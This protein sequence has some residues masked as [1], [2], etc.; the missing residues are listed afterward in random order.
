MLVLGLA[1]VYEFMICHDTNK[2][3]NMVQDCRIS[4]EHQIL[5]WSEMMHST[6]IDHAVTRISLSNHPM[7]DDGDKGARRAWHRCCNYGSNAINSWSNWRN[8]RWGYVLWDEQ[9][10]LDMGALPKYVERKMDLPLEWS[11]T[12]D[13][14][15]QW[16]IEA[17][18]HPF[19]KRAIGTRPWSPLWNLLGHLRGR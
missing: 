10:L 6:T 12:S 9:R 1:F 13:A 8:I 18:I 14:N 15:L 16:M 11:F 19:V 5:F 7:T 3:R 17:D 2:R 4:N